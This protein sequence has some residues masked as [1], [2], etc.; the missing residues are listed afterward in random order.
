MLALV[1][2]CGPTGLQGEGPTEAEFLASVLAP[3]LLQYAKV[4]VASRQSI[5]RVEDGL[6]L[7][8][9][10]GQPKLNGGI[11]AELSV[12]YPFV[13]GD[14]VRYE[15]SFWI[16]EDFTPDP[17]NRW[18]VFAN[19]HDQPD[20]TKGE[21]WEG[22]PSNS[23]PLILGYG[24]VE[25]GFE[26]DGFSIKETSDV[27]SVTYG[28]DHR[29]VALVPFSRGVWHQVRLDVRWSQ[30]SIGT[31]AMTLDGA[32]VV[33]AKGPNMLNA[34]QHY[35]KAGMY[36]DPTIDS[37]NRVRLSSLKIRTCTAAGRM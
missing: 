2:A 8:V 27:L 1:C 4:E 20:R 16:P 33:S 26:R 35:L 23:S 31:L 12:D 32:H 19:F 10:P 36:R 24:H 14:T 25:G 21:T 15:W 3:E 11:R 37:F 22:F 13:D 30:S 6:E 29:P 9:L 7:K 34:F 5:A 18:W 17:L 28:T